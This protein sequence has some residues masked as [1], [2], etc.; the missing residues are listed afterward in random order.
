MIKYWVWEESSASSLENANWKILSTYP[1][2]FSRQC[3]LSIILLVNSVTFIFRNRM[4]LQIVMLWASE[5][6]FSWKVKTTLKERPSLMAHQELS[7]KT[8]LK[9][10]EFWNKMILFRTQTGSPRRTGPLWG[11]NWTAS[12]R[13]RGGRSCSRITSLSRSSPTSTESG[14]RRGSSTPRGPGPL[15]ILRCI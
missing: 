1:I 5:K 14:F 10:N 9:E 7:W 4:I 3:L 12:A 11:T 8:A 15:D 2:S 6:D 13:G